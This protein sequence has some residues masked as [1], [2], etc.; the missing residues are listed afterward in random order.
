MSI[1]LAVEQKVLREKI[2]ALETRLANLEQSLNNKDSV[3]DEENSEPA[4]KALPKSLP[5]TLKRR[6]RPPRNAV[7]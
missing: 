1:R 6:G 7:G 2:E 4:P 3:C 5:K